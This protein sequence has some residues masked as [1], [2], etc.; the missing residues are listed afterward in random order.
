MTESAL[1]G[2]HSFFLNIFLGKL[3]I[4]S[5]L[6][7]NI[8]VWFSNALNGPFSKKIKILPIFRDICQN[9]FLCKPKIAFFRKLNDGIL[10]LTKDNLQIT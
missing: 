2:G 5:N 3:C 8:F 1:K 7:E 9:I 4:F 10:M 6:F